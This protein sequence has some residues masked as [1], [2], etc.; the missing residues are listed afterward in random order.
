MAIKGL[1]RSGV[2]QPAEP[3]MPEEWT[4]TGQLLSRNAIAVNPT[5]MDSAVSFV[6]PDGYVIDSFKV[7]S[8]IN[9]SGG[10]FYVN[11]TANYSGTTVTSSTNLTNLNYTTIVIS[12]TGLNS[13]V[14]GNSSISYEMK[15]IKKKQ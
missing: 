6:A 14:S 3:P 5:N 4:I 15:L 7:N 8:Y 1:W 2:L 13:N 10:T 11:Q 9:N 12:H